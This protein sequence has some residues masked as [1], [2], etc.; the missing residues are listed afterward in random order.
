MNC[1]RLIAARHGVP[2]ELRQEI[3]A[4]MR[5]GGL[6]GY[7]TDTVY[8]F[9]SAL[10][11]RGLEQLE[12]LKGREDDR[13]LLLLIDDPAGARDLDWPG[14]AAELANVFWPGGLTLVLNDGGENYPAPVRNRSGGVAVRVTPHPLAQAL[15]RAAGGPITSTSANVPGGS[16]A[17]SAEATLEAAV[18]LGAG[19]EF[20][21]LDGGPLAPS[22]PSTIVD[23]TGPEPV[24]LR[25]G[26]VPAHRLGCVLP[27]FVGGTDA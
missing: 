24:V 22:P 8:G 2:E 6:V 20:W 13:P 5:E 15:V 12:Q 9:G 7:P 19:P 17:L 10:C 23:C 14:Y 3:A 26:A 16:P 11:P 18:K 1:P 4:H 21:M 25:D 27:G